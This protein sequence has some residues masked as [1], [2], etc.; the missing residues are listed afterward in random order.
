MNKIVCSIVI[1]HYDIPEL[2]SRC[3]RS[4]PER[5]DIQ[6]IV[7]DDCSPK[8]KLNTNTVPEL[9]RENIELYYTPE[10]GSAGRARN[11]GIK[12]AKGEWITFLDA[13]DLLSDISDII[14]SDLI[15][16]KEDVLYFQSKSVMSDN[17]ELS[18]GRN[19]F[20]YH[21]QRYFNTGDEKLLRLEFDA[22]WGKIIR[23]SF[24]KKHRINFDEVRY[25]NDTFFSAAI[26]VFADKIYVSSKTLYIVTERE[27]SLTA[28]KMKSAEEWQIRYQTAL[29]V[30]HFFDKHSIRHRRYAFADFLLLMWERDKSRFFHE[31]FKLSLKNKTRYIYFVTR[32]LYS[33]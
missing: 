8:G 22:P 9:L 29:R 28:A 16:H 17:L 25:S 24:I 19:I 21:F 33:K 15:N 20:D 18:S 32:S 1:P 6:V 31:F 23:K 12:K 14:I 30:Q 10:G 27:G 11:I 7:V 4:I 13:D 2:L 5:N 3:L 26:G